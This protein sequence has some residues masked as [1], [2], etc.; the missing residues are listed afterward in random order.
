MDAIAC[1]ETLVMTYVR[2]CA[3]ATQLLIMCVLLPRLSSFVFFAHQTGHSETEQE[4]QSKLASPASQL[5][6]D[7]AH[8]ASEGVLSFHYATEN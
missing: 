4:Q 5:I 2:F 6:V 7:A 8:K 3:L 1:Y